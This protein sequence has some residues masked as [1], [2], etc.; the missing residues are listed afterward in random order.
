MIGLDLRHNLKGEIL[1]FWAL[2]IIN[3]CM[4]FRFLYTSIGQITKFLGIKCFS[5]K[6][7]ISEDKKNL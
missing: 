2:F 3:L 4:S 1:V 5:L 7:T 6:K